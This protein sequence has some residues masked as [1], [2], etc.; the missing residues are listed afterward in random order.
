MNPHQETLNTW[1]KVAQLYQEKFMDL[2]MYNESYVLFC[3]AIEKS[4]A[5]VL[6]IGCGPGNI[7]KQLLTL[8]ND[9]SM[10]G[11]DFSE[12][13]IMLAQ[14]NNPTAQFEVMDARDILKLN[15]S[16][17][18]IIAG[19]CLPYLSSEESIQFIIDASALLNNNGILYISF[20]EGDPT[21]SGFLAAS[22]GD[23]TYFYFHELNVLTKGIMDAG[24]EAPQMLHVNYG[25]A[26]SKQELHTILI[27][28]KL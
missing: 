4:K 10:Y 18:G 14:K 23:R 9:F 26:N 6:E 17:D 25:D 28:K 20:V 11:I 8:R 5:S 2:E 16:F 27:A 19:F 13:M 1:N 24:F 21:L 7:S 22:T 3:A 12:S 15:K